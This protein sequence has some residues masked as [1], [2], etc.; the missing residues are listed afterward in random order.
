MNTIPEIALKPRDRDALIQALRAGVVP[1]TGLR[2]VQVG[3][4]R[5]VEEA[6]KDM[7]RISGGGSAVRF[8]IGEYGSGKSFLLSLAQAVAREEKL[9]TMKADLS[10]NVRLHSTQGH[11]RALVRLL[12]ASMATRA[13]PDGGALSAVV[14][15]LMDTQDLES[16]LSSLRDME[17]GH[18]L[19]QA[20]LKFAEGFEKDDEN[21]K[22]AALRWMRAEYETRAQ[23]REELGVRS[24][25]DDSRAILH[26]R[27]MSEM[28]RLAGFGG[29][30]I[31]IDECVNIV[32]LQSSQARSSSYE[33]ILG[34]VN[35]TLQG[36][37]GHIG[38]W[39]GGT[40]E[41]LTGTRRG[42]YS[43]EALKSRLAENDF[44]RANG[45]IDTSGPV[46]RLSS[47]TPEDIYIL[48]GKL[49]ALF[50]EVSGGHDMIRAF[51]ERSS[52]TLGDAAFRT[53]RMT[54]KAFLDLLVVLE[55]NKGTTWQDLM[56]GVK[57]E[58]DSGPVEEGLDESGDADDLVGFKL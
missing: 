32:K 28:C 48:L 17:G 47:L 20:C 10:P 30:F 34:I 3:R 21:L 6:V 12:V 58:A 11:A 52:R 24:I 27:G 7:R 19:A 2:H 41:F 1:R 55:Q 49:S 39:F 33:E 4:A 56:P 14:E 50:P 57:I 18:D 22:S 44:A 36:T 29:L 31:T 16:R 25:V 35:A 53:P 9:V 51:M 23:A 15:R 37:Q 26:L 43:Y 42:M 13:K 8:I 38:F 46:L 40:P 45:L 5:E 54:I